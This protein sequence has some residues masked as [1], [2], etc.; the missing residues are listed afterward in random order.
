MRRRPRYG[1]RFAGVPRT[2]DRH[3]DAEDHAVQRVGDRHGVV[4]GVL[5]ARRRRLPHREAHE[6]L[7]ATAVGDQHGRPVPG[8]PILS[9]HPVVYVLRR[10]DLPDHGELFRHRDGGHGDTAHP[11]LL[12]GRQAR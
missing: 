11:R 1:Q 4:A 6:T 2:H 10:R 7:P 8:G 5:P 12:G 3:V 9:V